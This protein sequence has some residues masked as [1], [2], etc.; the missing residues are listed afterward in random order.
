LISRDRRA[1]PVWWPARHAGI[2][3]PSGPAVALHSQPADASTR[4]VRPRAGVSGAGGLAQQAR[5][6][7]PADGRRFPGH[8]A[9]VGGIKCC[10]SNRIALDVVAQPQRGRCWFGESSRYAPT[11]RS[12]RPHQ[13]AASG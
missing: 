1:A 13:S 10:R 9:R 6:G 7:P 5:F 2:D 11:R 4:H 8:R 12:R 3:P